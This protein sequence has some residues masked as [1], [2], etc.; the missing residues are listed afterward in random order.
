MTAVISISMPDNMKAWLDDTNTSASQLFQE[1]ITER[2]KLI[3]EHV[4]PQ[5]REYRERIE[6]LSRVIEEK[7]REIERLNPS[8]S[9]PRD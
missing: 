5:M 8:P 9:S 2:M 3:Q 4:A 6:K 7:N 1:A